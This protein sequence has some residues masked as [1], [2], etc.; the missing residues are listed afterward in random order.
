M[1][2]NKSRSC[3]SLN[4]STKPIDSERFTSRVCSLSLEFIFCEPST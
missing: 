2:L 3:C 1:Q 4:T